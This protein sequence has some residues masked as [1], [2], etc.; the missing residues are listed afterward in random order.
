MVG[1]LRAAGASTGRERQCNKRNLE[2][3]PSS[4][5]FL[6]YFSEIHIHVRVCFTAK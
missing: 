5:N 1:M 6:T 4:N 3:A 2:F